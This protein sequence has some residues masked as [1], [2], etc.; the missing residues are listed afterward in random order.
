VD[1]LDREREE[2]E[3]GGLT[4]GEAP[5]PLGFHEGIGLV[6]GHLDLLPLA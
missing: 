2:G 3:E 1:Q 4:G 6:A 5:A